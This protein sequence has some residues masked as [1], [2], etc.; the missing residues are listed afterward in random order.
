MHGYLDPLRALLERPDKQEQYLRVIENDST[1]KRKKRDYPAGIIHAIRR[2]RFNV[3][4][5]L[6]QLPASARLFKGREI[7]VAVCHGHIEIV[8]LLYEHRKQAGLKYD[9]EAVMTVAIKEG[10]LE[11]MKM[12]YT[13]MEMK[14][15]KR[16]HPS[17]STRLRK[18]VKK[19]RTQIPRHYLELAC[20]SGRLEVVQWVHESKIPGV[21]T[22]NAF[23]YAALGHL[24]IV[25]YLHEHR[26]EG[27]TCNAWV[28]AAISGNLELIQFLHKYRT[29]SCT[30]MVM[31]Q[32][33]YHGHLDI[34][35]WLH[36]N[37]TEGCGPIAVD[38]AAA[39]GH[40]T[41]VKWLMENRTERCTH[42]AVE[43]A[44]RNRRL[45][46][47]R[48]LLQYGDV[49]AK[50][51]SDPTFDK[52]PDYAVTVNSILVDIQHKSNLLIVP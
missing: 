6:Y 33:A 49:V 28:N 48:Y 30:K 44:I 47:A 4:K 32:A 50:V 45:D 23:D 41:V 43:H 31:A 5:Y 46:I 26:T 24:D 38:L 20:A 36:H 1:M 51:Q 14:R 11:K 34:V 35:Q 27:G 10:R 19:P 13:W 7:D 40:L 12:V 17:I 15:E 9:L 52:L 18:I 21:C 37:R 3:I 8:R 42:S 25:K 39:N 29:E 16:E 2:N 22:T